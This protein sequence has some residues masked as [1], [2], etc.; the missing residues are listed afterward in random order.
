MSTFSQVTVVKGRSANPKVRPSFDHNHL[1]SD[2]QTTL[3]GLQVA[4]PVKHLCRVDQ[5][6]SCRNCRRALE[7]AL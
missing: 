7:A 6:Y 1:T 4:Y 2:G 5:A 3:C